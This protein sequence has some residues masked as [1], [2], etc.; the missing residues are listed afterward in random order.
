MTAYT[1]L[2]GWA[3]R[4]YDGTAAFC[5][6]RASVSD[7]CFGQTLWKLAERFLKLVSIVPRESQLGPVLQIDAVLA[8]KPRLQFPNARYP[9]D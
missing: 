4:F 1:R 9:H 8:M 3:E 2:F 7:D 6:Q 5:D